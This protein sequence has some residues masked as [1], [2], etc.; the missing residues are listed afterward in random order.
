VIISRTPFRISF[1]G[2]GT[3]IPSFYHK[4]GG[5]VIST[6][7]RKYMYVLTNPRFGDASKISYME[8]EIVKDPQQIK[9]RIIRECL[10]FF[11]INYP[12]EVV[13]VA[14]IPKGTGLGSSSSLTVGLLHNLFCDKYLFLPSKEWLAA[15]ACHVEINRL[16]QP[17]GKQDQYAAA[18]GGFN[19][20]EFLPDESVRVEPIR[21]TR[22]VCDELERNLLCFFTGKTHDSNMILTRQA[23]KISQ[24]REILLMM[25]SQAYTVADCLKSGDLMRFGEEL[26]SAWMYKRQ[27]AEGIT[28]PL[29]DGMF[30]RAIRAG[31]VGGKLCG[32]GSGGFMVFYVPKRKHCRVREALSGFKELEVKFDVE[33]SKIIH[34]D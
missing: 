17:I 34:T 19:L 23:K 21:V 28:N 14:D 2:G 15:T 9:H 3:D 1:A 27:L 33:G 10:L 29:V 26:H 8:T 4:Y 13:T 7:I 12:I 6:T 32:A 22:S 31:A 24:N 20:I 5:A 11:K 16:M 18:Y 25:K 30:K